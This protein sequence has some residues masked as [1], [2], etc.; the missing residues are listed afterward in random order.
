LQPRELFAKMCDMRRRLLTRLFLLI[1]FA[2][3][4]V[5]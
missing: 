2:F 5:L 1:V 4:G 3:I